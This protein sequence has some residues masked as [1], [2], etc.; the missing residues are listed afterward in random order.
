MK[1]CKRCD[2]LIPRNNY[3]GKC[4]T[5]NFRERNP[6]RMETLCAQYYEKNKEHVIKRVLKH[7]KEN[8]EQTN[9]SH[10]KWAKSSNYDMNRYRSDVQYK[11]IK[12]QRARI[13]A[14]LKGLNKSQTTQELLGCTT[15]FLK[16]YIESKFQPGMTWDNYAIDG[17]HIDHIIPISK[18]DLTVE[19]ELKKACHYTNLQPMWWRDNIVKG[20]K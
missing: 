9:I 8:P 4:Y 16:E 6:G 18:F 19:D 3:C 15:E 20:N 13:N 12:T 11:L 17:W 1:N 7:K 14:A 2:K 10:A 5:L